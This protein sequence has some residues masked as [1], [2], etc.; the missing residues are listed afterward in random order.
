MPANKQNHLLRFVVTFFFFYLIITMG[1]K[2]LFPEKFSNEV[3]APEE[4]RMTLESKK[5]TMGR[6]FSVTIINTTNTGITLPNLCPEPPVVIE[7][8]VGDKLYQID[9]TEPVTSCVPV[10][11][12]D[13]DN[14]MKI[15]LSPWKYSA[16]T[17]PGAYKISLEIPKV[18]NEKFVG[19][20]TNKVIE[21]ETKVK[22]PGAFVSLF[23]TFISKPLLN[24]MILIASLIPNHSLGWSI[25]ILT[26]IIKSLL[27]FPS[28]H[29]LESQKKL[30]SI[31]PKLDEIK[32]KFAGNQQKITEETMA[33]WKREK[34][35]P[36]QSCLPTLLQLPILI[37]LFFIVRDSGSLDL[38]R[39]LLYPPF[40]SL[41]WTFD[42]NFLGVLDLNMIPFQSV[43]SWIPPRPMTGLLKG[44]FLPVVIAASQFTQMKMS[45]AKKAAKSGGSKPQKKTLEDHLNMQNMMMYMLPTMLIFISGS[46]PAAV[47]V[48][49]GASTAFA[50]GQQYYVNRGK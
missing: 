13:P 18:G 19:N 36:L 10:T 16:F 42:T 27:F 33:I 23:R 24:G 21:I 5:I 3:K 34:I 17:E 25:I 28:Q 20:L 15:D 45:F 47:S 1:L 29:A 35:N 48:Y 49:W 9:L 41:D 6:D 12:I 22:T 11:N 39:H 31:Q 40:L 14:K 4:I 30:Q 32:K 26:I 8:K 46:L 2:A 50:I 37:G 7:R 44:L 43:E 38:A